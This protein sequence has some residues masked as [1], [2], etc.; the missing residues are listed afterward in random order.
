MNVPMLPMSI[1]ADTGTAAAPL[2][3]YVPNRQEAENI[4]AASPHI[5][6]GFSVTQLRLLDL[7]GS[8]GKDE[9]GETSPTQYAFKTVFTLVSNAEALL[10]RYGPPGSCSVD[11]TGGIRTTWSM[12]GREVRLVCPADPAENVYFYVEADHEPPIVHKEPITPQFLAQLLNQWNMRE[13]PAA[14]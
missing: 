11:S 4:C 9:Y 5:G 1:F 13:R 8:T 6:P 14:G 10:G 2:H 12:P 3:T 7:L